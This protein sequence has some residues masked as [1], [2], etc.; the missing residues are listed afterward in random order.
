M[1]DPWRPKQEKGLTFDTPGFALLLVTIIVFIFALCS[2]R[3]NI[4]FVAV[5]VTL[6]ISLGCL[7]GAYWHLAQEN[8]AFGERLTIVSIVST[9]W[10]EGEDTLLMP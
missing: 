6:D 3:T 1:K 9:I 10:D 7:T 5:F 4:V 8:M 2:V